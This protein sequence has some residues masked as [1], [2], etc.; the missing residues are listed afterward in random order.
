[1][2]KPVDGTPPLTLELSPSRYLAGYVAISHSALLAVTFFYP[3]AGIYRS[4][5]VVIVL[6]HW[7]AS[8]R[9]VNNPGYS[10]WISGLIYSG[11]ELQIVNGDGREA[12]LITEATVWSWLVVINMCAAG[13]RQRYRLV[14][15]PDSTG[16]EQQRQLRVF[17]RHCLVPAT[18]QDGA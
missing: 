15:L 18:G 10:G 16:S 6:L 12:V 5:L 7:V 9:R 11:A 8:S 13:G 4:V 1:M 17:L 3:I 14:I 2:L